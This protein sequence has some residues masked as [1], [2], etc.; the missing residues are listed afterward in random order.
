MCPYRV[1]LPIAADSGR[2]D[3]YDV[4]S[5]SPIFQQ[6]S[7]TFGDRVPVGLVFDLP[8][9]EPLTV[10][11]DSR[12]AVR[13]RDL[14]RARRSSASL[15]EPTAESSIASRCSRLSAGVLS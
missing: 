13:V 10:A 12:P 14:P 6:I 1:E 15:N 9:D 4:D 8:R 5:D 7:A 3:V 2:A 11:G